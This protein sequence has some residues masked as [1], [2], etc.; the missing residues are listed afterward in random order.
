M[1]KA[2]FTFEMDFPLYTYT[3]VVAG[4]NIIELELGDFEPATYYSRPSGIMQFRQEV[5]E[6]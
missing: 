2:E 6:S 4:G 1:H 5:V 3:K